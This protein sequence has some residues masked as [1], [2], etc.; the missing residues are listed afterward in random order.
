MEKTGD[1]ELC[2]N[3]YFSV[4]EEKKVN[5][6]DQEDI[7]QR[8]T[9]MKKGILCHFFTVPK[10]QFMKCMTIDAKVVWELDVVGDEER[11]DTNDEVQLA[12]N[13]TLEE[14]LAEAQE[15]SMLLV[16]LISST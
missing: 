14:Y 1:Y 3:N 16:N 11:F 5:I 9:I 6:F 4:M 7:F 13:Q 10:E 2:F 15:V 12:I 8:W